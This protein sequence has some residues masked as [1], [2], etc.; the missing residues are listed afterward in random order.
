MRVYIHSAG[1][2]TGGQG[3]RIKRAFDRHVPDV[4]VRATTVAETYVGYPSD[5]LLYRDG[6]AVAQRLYEEADVVHLM[7]TLTALRRIGI[8]VPQKPTVLHHH[9][10]RFRAQH[11]SIAAEARQHGAVQL[12][13]TLDLEVLEP[14]VKWL[15]SPHDLA[16]LASIR[17][18]EYRPSDT[19]RIAHAPT[20]RV[21]KSTESVIAS[22]ETLQRRGR[23]V[24]LDLIENESW[25]AC[26]RRKAR[27]DILVDQLFLGYGNN[28]I[29]AWAM[30]IP[31][32][33]GVS[34]AH[35]PGTRQRMLSRF[36]LLPFYEAT[37]RTLIEA[38]D[39]LVSEPE[40]RLA[41][42]SVGLEHARRFHSEE[43]VARTL[44]GIYAGMVSE[45]SAVV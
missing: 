19:V 6:S 28:A 30:G 9:G 32:V 34:E 36:G 7:N 5:V 1:Q 2:D 22:V 26:L 40:A 16:Y 39:R 31:V 27:A 12:V 8:P 41:F 29:E 43:S 14:D 44:H 10:S 17:R 42:G 38:L 11:S 20:N 23:N 24:S 4:S 45:W 21:I 3:Y 37:E 13:S 35:A 25:E 15:P 18:T 33:A